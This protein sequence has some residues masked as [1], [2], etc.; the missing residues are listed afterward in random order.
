MGLDMYLTADKYYYT[1]KDENETNMVIKR[2]S[3]RY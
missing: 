2:V 1:F 3:G